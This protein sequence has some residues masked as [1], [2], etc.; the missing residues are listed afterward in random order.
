[1]EEYFE[2][3]G[4]V[5]ECVVKIEKDSHR[6]RGFG[7]IIFEDTSSA[8]AVLSHL[9]H[10]LDGKRIDCKLAIPKPNSKGKK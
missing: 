3:F 5:E 2:R 10:V 6:S 1:M 7:F 4:P 8:E 9:D